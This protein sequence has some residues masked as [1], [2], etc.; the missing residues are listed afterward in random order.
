MNSVNLMG[1][2]YKVVNIFLLQ[3]HFLQPFFVEFPFLFLSVILG[4]IL[5]LS[6]QPQLLNISLSSV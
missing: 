4:Q 3:N 1:H 5:W 2:R 6:C